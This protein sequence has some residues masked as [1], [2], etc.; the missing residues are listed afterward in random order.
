MKRYIKSASFGGYKYQYEVHW[1][2]PDGEDELLGASKTLKG[3]VDIAIRQINR[4]A[5]NPFEE[6][7]RKYHFIDNTYIYDAKSDRVIDDY[8]L[9]EAQDNLMS[10][11]DSRIR[12]SK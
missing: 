4:V 1:V 12:M 6:D 7:E 10:M 5:E 8:T 3:A 11:L 2:S 9:E